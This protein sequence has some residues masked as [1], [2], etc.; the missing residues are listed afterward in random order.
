MTEEN[1][2]IAELL[3][4]ANIGEDFKTFVKS[5]IGVYLINAA[6]NAEIKAL[7]AL[8]KVDCAAKDKIYKLQ[9]DAAVPRRMVEFMNQA[10]TTGANAKF[11]LDEISS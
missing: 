5:N 9:M 6:E 3:A 1:S 8:S 2:L 4:E 11:Q 7:R 10:I